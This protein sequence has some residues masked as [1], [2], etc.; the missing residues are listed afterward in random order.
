VIS[1][2][3]ST[4]TTIAGSRYIPF[5]DGIAAVNA[6]VGSV[7]GV[8]ADKNGNVYF[9]DINTNKVYRVATNGIIATYAGSGTAG[10]AGDGGPARYLRRALQSP[11]PGLRRP[12][13]PSQ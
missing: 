8:T 11:W 1:S 3:Q 2:A 4:I 12:R 6:P 9:S 13:Q 7:S 5:Q 10:Y